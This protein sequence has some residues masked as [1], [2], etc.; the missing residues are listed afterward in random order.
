MIDEAVE[1]HAPRLGHDH[2]DGRLTTRGVL[3][4]Q[5][6]DEKEQQFPFGAED[7]VKA[8]RVL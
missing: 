8:P 4:E 7:A 1:R 2:F 5:V 3:R 6:D